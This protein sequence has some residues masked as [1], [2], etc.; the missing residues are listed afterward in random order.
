MH[1]ILNVH[2]RLRHFNSAKQDP[3]LINRVIPF[4]IQII[5]YLQR[6]DDDGIEQT[7]TE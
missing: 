2:L 1:K 7:Q 3:C 5:S 6:K 4:Q